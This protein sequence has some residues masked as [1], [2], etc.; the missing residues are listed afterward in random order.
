MMIAEQFQRPLCDVLD[1]DQEIA[2]A[3]L[4]AL[5]S[6]HALPH[7]RI[8]FEVHNGWITLE[9]EVEWLH[10]R[11]EAGETIRRI[12]GAAGYVNLITV[13]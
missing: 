5:A 6:S 12:E 4:R 8:R 13:G 2:A 7:D 3:A 9:G 11:F 1:R 10:E